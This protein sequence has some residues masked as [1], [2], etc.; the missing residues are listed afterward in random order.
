MKRNAKRYLPIVLAII[1]AALMLARPG[2][3]AEQKEEKKAK[4]EA[5]PAGNAENGKRLYTSYGCY[6][7]HGREAQGAPTGPRLGP[8][9][10]PFEAFVAYSRAPSGDMPPYTA[11]VVSDADWADMYA[12]VKALPQP[13]PVKDIPLLNH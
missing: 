10:M 11:K 3:R 5:V 8:D 7:C 9:P 1:A 2:A 12:F 4:A 6:Q 13:P